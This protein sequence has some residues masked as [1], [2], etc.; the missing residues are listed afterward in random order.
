MDNRT[1]VGCRVQRPL[2]GDDSFL[3][4]SVL[5]ETVVLAHF[6]KTI[7]VVHHAGGPRISPDGNRMTVKEKRAPQMV[8]L[9]H[10][11][12]CFVGG[13]GKKVVARKCN[14]AANFQSIYS[15]TF[16]QVTTLLSFINRLQGRNKARNGGRTAGNIP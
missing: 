8:C 14:N 12:F 5:G 7:N 10:S 6:W 16:S 13:E 4:P 9:L 11:V 2:E 15:H 3:L 1:P